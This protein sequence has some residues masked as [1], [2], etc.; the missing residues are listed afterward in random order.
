MQ[1]DYDE[2][3]LGKEYE[4]QGKN[5]Y[6][7]QCRIKGDDLAHA[8]VRCITRDYTGGRFAGRDGGCGGSRGCGF[9]YRHLTDGISGR[10]AQAHILQ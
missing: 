7:D 3:K 6:T 2:V 1:C 8:A 10:V 5:E 4:Y 9:H